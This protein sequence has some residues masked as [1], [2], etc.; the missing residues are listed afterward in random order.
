MRITV[1]RNKISKR[2]RVRWKTKCQNAWETQNIVQGKS[3]KWLKTCR[4]KVDNLTSS[5]SL[6]PGCSSSRTETHE[7]LQDVLISEYAEV[8]KQRNVS[9]NSQILKKIYTW[10]LNDTCKCWSFKTHTMQ[11]ATSN[12]EELIDNTVDYIKPDDFDDIEVF[13]STVKYFNVSFVHRYTQYF[14]KN[15]TNKSRLNCS[16]LSGKTRLKMLCF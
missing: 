16:Y 14:Y 5:S 6:D 4:L 3:L 8:P 15:R 9:P 10:T 1:F 13:S 7:N 11:Y 12:C 2:L